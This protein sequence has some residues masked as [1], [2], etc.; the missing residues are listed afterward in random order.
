MQD[1]K[2]IFL[3]FVGLGYPRYDEFKKE[4]GDRA[5]NCEASEATALDIS[6]GLSL[7]GK[8][9]FVYSITPFILWRGAEV[10]RTYINI[11]QLNV[12]IIGAGR[13]ED[14]SKHDGF[15][16]DATD[17]KD[18]IK[19]F[20]NIKAHWPSENQLEFVIDE[21]IQHDGADYINLTR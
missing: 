12:K 17:D 2:D 21:A 4:F 11:E 16:H 20:K 18:F 15:S 6:C 7:S 8:I 9:P 3:L 5:V 10:I 1:N 19:L 14:Y 13:N